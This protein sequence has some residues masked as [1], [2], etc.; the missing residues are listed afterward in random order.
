MANVKTCDLAGS[1]RA[2]GAEELALWHNQGFLGPYTA[3][4]P[5]EAAE[6]K[7]I[8]L[9]RMS[10]PSQ[11]Y[12]FKTVRD[13]HLDSATLFKACTHPAIVERCASI[14]G[15][16]L[17]LWR[18]N[19]FHKPPGCGPVMWHR[20]RDFQSAKNPCH[21]STEQCHLLAGADRCQQS[22]WLRAAYSRQPQTRIQDEHLTVRDVVYLAVV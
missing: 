8:I 19:F 12:G 4:S 13:R 18:S 22:E 7:P 14:L 15:P 6:F 20:G 17:L 3:W 11:I 1:P 2:S 21:R 5:E 16:D 9:D 10:C